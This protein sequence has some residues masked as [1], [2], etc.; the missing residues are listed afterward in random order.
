ML[1]MNWRPRKLLILHA[2]V[3]G[4]PPSHFK[5]LDSARHLTG[6]P[7]LGAREIVGDIARQWWCMVGGAYGGD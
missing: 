7:L 4:P 3:V 5:E 6:R 1:A 2:A